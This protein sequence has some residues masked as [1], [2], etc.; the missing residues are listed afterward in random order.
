M[1]HAGFQVDTEPR[2]SFLCCMSYQRRK[3]GDHL[4]AAGL[5]T[6]EQ[7]A[8]ALE[9]QATTREKLG[10]VLV[11]LGFLT[12]DQVAQGLAEQLGLALYRPEAPPSSELLTL[13]PRT[14]MEDRQIV[15]VSL[16]KNVLTL[17]MA[18]PLD[19]TTIKDVQFLT[20]VSV[21][22]LVATPSTV[23]GILRGNIAPPQNNV[24][25]ALRNIQPSAEQIEVVDG[26]EEDKEDILKLRQAGEAAPVISLVNTLLSE[27]VKA[28]SSDIHIEPRGRDALVRFRIDG[29]LRDMTVLQ[30]ALYPPVV[31]RLKIM[32]KM[33]ISVRLRPQDGST[34]IRMGD[35]EI[36][37]RISTLPTVYGEKMVIRILDKSRQAISLKD[38]GM[39]PSDLTT[40]RSFL[41]RPQGMILV[42]GPTGSGKTTT[43]YAALQQVRSEAVNIITVEDP[44]EYLIPGINQVRVNERA[45]ITFASGLRSIL[46]QD[47]N[48]IM[49]GEIRDRETAE[50]AFQSSL[51]GHLVLSTLHTNNA[52]AAITRLTDIGVEPY[53]VA[54]S[55]IGILA[56]RLIRRNCPWCLAP[57]TPDGTVLSDLNIEPS[58]NQIRFHRGMGCEKCLNAGYRGRVG[59]YEILKIDDAVRDLIVG[60]ATERRILRQ[61]RQA[62]MSTMEE[63]GLYKSVRKITTP[64]EILRVLP[65]EE[66]DHGDGESSA[67]RARRRREMAAAAVSSGDLEASGEDPPSHGTVI[68]VEGN[69]GSLRDLAELFVQEG[70]SFTVCRLCGEVARSADSGLSPTVV[71]DLFLEDGDVGDL[72]RILS[73]R[74][75]TK[76]V[77]L[78]AVDDGKKSPGF[79]REFG[80]DTDRIIRRPFDL[81]E[82][83][84]KLDGFP[85]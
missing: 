46:R 24:R 27:A 66:I 14:V 18:D 33:D 52:V 48:I 40:L 49:V 67:D 4:F 63:D 25:E 9:R 81:A 34:K 43:L 62:G 83:S 10:R 16:E 41:S 19:F 28:D 7:L 23:E 26:S 57:Y 53:L 68:L 59:I 76:G 31:S 29:L 64:E 32:G 58:N 71:S 74:E 61:A 84:R 22:P 21:K 45:G 2:L 35:R 30:P 20:G 15:P 72:E 78:I 82:V 12:E 85:R 11:S 70:R 38:L 3:I 8:A 5:I 17:A 47:P 60:R 6:A 80:F 79:L 69:E 77:R 42:T 65:P 55:V 50:I 51:T 56:Q 44:V 36:D 54:S 13:L 39:L 37:L 75:E 73:E 1:V